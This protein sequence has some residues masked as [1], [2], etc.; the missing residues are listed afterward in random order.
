MISL[1]N[2]TH[3]FAPSPI[4]SAA[5]G[6]A[7]EPELVHGARPEATSTKVE[8]A[9][10]LIR[11]TA[12]KLWAGS[13]AGVGGIV[14]MLLN[15]FRWIGRKVGQLGAQK[16]GAPA[17]ASAAGAGA[18]ERAGDDNNV[19]AA[20]KAN[21]QG[22]A[23][24]DPSEVV[25][26]GGDGGYDDN[27][28]S[29]GLEDSESEGLSPS[30]PAQALRFPAG[31]GGNKLTD[32]MPVD[33]ETIVSVMGRMKAKHPDLDSADPNE[34]P[35][36]AS[37]CML[38]E[39][40]G[41]LT[42]AQ[43]HA[44]TLDEQINTHLAALGETPAN[45]L[46]EQ[47]LASSDLGGQQGAEIRRLHAERVAQEMTVV[48][49][50]RLVGVALR[51]VKQQGLDVAAVALRTK[52]ADA[53]PDWHARIE[54]AEAPATTGPT[55]LTHSERQALALDVEPES[56][57]ESFEPSQE[58]VASLKAALI[59]NFE[60]KNEQEPEQDRPRG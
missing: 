55:A 14:A 45:E 57:S 38:E 49:C 58:R 53:L 2:A 11:E 37:E 17:N 6:Q 4:A 1:T 18:G 48:E 20:A 32:T 31:Y 40:L 29:E 12:E 8:D 5:G 22:S 16:S 26:D 60:N 51:E 21:T 30:K 44:R 50:Q 42:R 23:D 54:S 15:F 27:P 19:Y 34:L 52:V 3:S 13:K 41:K 24:S 43:A 9:A 28:L 39:S 33:A 36:S 35:L 59:S 7:H 46:L 25:A 56:D 47:V 10:R